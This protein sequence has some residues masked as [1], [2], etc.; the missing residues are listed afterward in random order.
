MDKFLA[1]LIKE[2]MELLRSRGMLFF[3]F[4]IFVINIY[5][6]GVGVNL[7]ARGVNVG[8]LDEKGGSVYVSKIVASLH[9]PEFKEILYYSSRTLLYEDIKNKKI[10]AGL[11]FPGTF[12]SDIA[13]GKETKIQLLL[14]TT[15]ATLSYYTYTHLVNIVNTFQTASQLR[16]PVELN[17]H[18]LYNP[19]ASSVPF[20]TLKELVSA[21]T[22]LSIILSAAVFVKEKE[23]DTWNLML[24]VPV[25]PYVMILAKLLSQVAVVMVGFI[26]SLGLILFGLFDLPMAGN[27]WA[28]FFMT[29]LYAIATSGIGLVIASVARNITH[30][31]LMT[32]MAIIP[33]TFLSGGTSSIYTKPELVQWLSYLSPLRYYT[34]GVYN[35]V[36]RGTEVIHLWEQFLGIAVIATVLIVYGVKKIGKLF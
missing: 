31:G 14:D 7:D 33:L 17:I 36:F 16:V 4:Y 13:T 10:V 2:W 20:I 30:V 6:A 27:F 35:L 34:E 25:N 32:I 11:I 12:D 19:N 1:I 28:L 21:I 18:K 9:P 8:I 15:V 5:I 3:I 24:L 23:Q 29:F 26:L 22:L